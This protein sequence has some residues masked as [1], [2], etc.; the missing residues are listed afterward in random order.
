MNHLVWSLS[1]SSLEDDDES[2]SDFDSEFEECFFFLG[3]LVFFFETMS[4]S[5]LELEWD[6]LCL[7]FSDRRSSL[8]FL[9]RFGD[10]EFDRDSSRL[11]FL[12]FFGE[13]LEDLGGNLEWW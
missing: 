2:E 1:E 9:F 8:C 13:C 7:R 10:L 6:R 5:E 4:F 12:A 3:F 11:D